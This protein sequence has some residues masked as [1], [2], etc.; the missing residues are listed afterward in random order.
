M[1]CLYGRHTLW[2]YLHAYTY[3]GRT[4]SRSEDNKFS[5]LMLIAVIMEPMFVRMLPS[6]HSGDSYQSGS[7]SI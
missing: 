4:D 5:L 7:P 6:D 2:S 3:I 1:N